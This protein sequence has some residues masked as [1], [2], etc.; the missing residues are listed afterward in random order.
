MPITITDPAPAGDFGQLFR[1]SATTDFIGPLVNP[2]WRVYVTDL[3]DLGQLDEQIFV[4]NTTTRTLDQRY[5]ANQN[6]VA[7]WPLGIA[8]PDN[9]HLHVELQQNSG[10]VEQ[11]VIT[12]KASNS[13]TPQVTRQHLDQI[14]TNQSGTTNITAKLDSVL[15]AVTRNFGPFVGVLSDLLLHP[16]PGF[17]GRELIGDFTDVQAFTRP[18][19]GVG[20]NAF[21]ITWEVVS[22]GGGIGI[23]PGTPVEFHTNLLQLEIVGTDGDGHEFTAAA[24][25]WTISNYYYLFDT[26]FPTRV[27]VA[28]AP[29]VTM[30]FYWLVIA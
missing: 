8:P 25:E 12:V 18:A 6:K 17:L 20:V 28:I 14:E 23:D 13:L 24:S 2:Y 9:V 26:S 16:S 30:R 19:P 15:A 1:I 4:F 10:L 29:S 11:S 7:F 3:D 22:Y 21:G 5:T 27:Q